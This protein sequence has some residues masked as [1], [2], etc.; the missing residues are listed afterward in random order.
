MHQSVRLLLLSLLTPALFAADNYEIAEGLEMVPA[1]T[2]GL[3]RHPVMAN[4]DD[5]GRLFVAENAGLNLNKEELLAQ[6]PNFVSLLVDTD[7][8]GV[9]D[10]KTIFADG[11]TFPQGA[12]WVYDSLYVMSPPSL[13]R[14]ADEDG[15]GVAEVR[16]E[17]VTG[18]DFTGN[19]A[20]VH[21]P[22]LHPNG[23][24]YWCHGRK[25]FAIPDND[26]GQI[27]ETGKGARVWSSQLSGGEVEAFA[28]GGMDNPVEVD[29][30][31]EGEILGTVNL[32]YGRPR[33]DTLTHWVHGGAYP[34][35]DQQLVIDEF[36]KTGDLLPPVHNFGHIAISGMSR[37]RGTALNPE[38]KDNWLIS[39]FNTSKITRTV[40]EQKGASF[41]ATKTE[42]I[43]QLNEPDSHF[44]DVF[45]DRE[46]GLIVVDT[47]GWFR[48]GCPNSQ[49]A[50][51]EISGGLYRIRPKDTTAKKPGAMPDWPR[52]TS[53]DVSGFLDAPEFWIRDR[54]I[55]ELAVRGDP[56]FP[57][58]KRILEDTNTS[59]MARRNA[60][61]TLTR[62]KFSE[63]TDLIYAALT[64][65]SPSV[66]QTACNGILVTR[67]WQS[68]AANEPAERQIELDRN[69]TI[70]GALASMVRNDTPSVARTAAAA[71]GVMGEFRAI[72][73]ILGR[74]GR[75]ADDRFLEH[76]LIYAL[77]EIDDYETTKNALSSE[78]PRVIKGALIA[79]NEM[80]ESKLEALDVL[81]FLAHP[82]DALRK[83]VHQICVENHK[84]DAALANR[85]IRWN[86]DFNENRLET[87]FEIVPPFLDS[88]PMQGFVTS[89]LRS[90]EPLRQDLGLQLIAAANRIPFQPEWTEVFEANLSDTA[91]EAT[92]ASTLSAL[93]AAPSDQFTDLLKGI[94]SNDRVS[95]LS[96]VKAARCL[97]K[98]STAIADETFA[99]LIDLLE[100]ET[101]TEARAE[102]IAMLSKS[103]LTAAHREELAKLLGQ[104][105]IV[106]LGSFLD[107]FKKIDTPELAAQLGEIIFKSPAFPNLPIN[108]LRQ[109]FK[110]FPEITEQ[111]EARQ[112]E[113]EAEKAK[114]DEKIES[115]VE[116]LDG[117]DPVR[118]A[119]I[120]KSGKGT[121]LVCH[122]ID[123]DG[124][125][126]GPELSTIGRIRTARDLFESILYPS[127]SIARDF[128]TFQVN[129]KGEA[130]PQLGLIE[131][132]TQ[133]DIE[134]IDIAGQKHEIPRSA[135]ESIE[136]I[137][138]SLMPMGLD[139]TLAPDELSDLVAYLLSLK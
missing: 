94:V 105:S 44:T 37:Y 120:F 42:T 32:F 111:L 137:P 11:L 134:L 17:L 139:G 92:L 115:L 57:E 106:E 61:W 13:W 133:S 124:G 54:A 33:G 107:L 24:L 87:L 98:N 90:E 123:S 96:R 119:E 114:R 55:T 71:L 38:W 52:Y 100:N 58:L 51:P 72:G 29:F 78:N 112:E 43:F 73:A 95:R 64:D 110:P 22:F 48:I 49:I 5:N 135:I 3:V 102:S 50:K 25:G 18:F 59:E 60:L 128:E 26:T 56:A 80:S 27:M 63:A 103:A 99:L 117:A 86:S 75:V 40:T 36:K 82:N 138:A 129:L 77:I 125:K 35:Y 113:V 88:P 136:R 19:A 118:G 10:K 7:K 116:G 31:E 122:K 14:F 121:C 89:L 2:P 93:L 23:R 21:G 132:R 30:T 4:Y 20:D 83:T 1:T 66:R 15:D 84:W 67:S 69:K 104:F 81:P 131:K 126:I 45:E 16:E 79:L 70:S 127:E 91:T 85:F 108:Q 76:A 74:M 6:K 62:M 68:I 47:G 8:D 41:I 34:R 53:E 65:P 12:L 101:D 109:R 9:F 46:G 130:P 39:H 28:G 97:S